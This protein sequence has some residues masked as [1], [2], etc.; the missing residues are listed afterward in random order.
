MHEFLLVFRRDYK[1]KSVQPSPEKLQE[2]LKHWTEWFGKLKTEDKL[3]VPPQRF[4]AAG[5]VLQHD[6]T[7]VDGPVVEHK[8]SIGGL[9]FIK[10]KDYMEA[11]KIAKGCPTLELGG[12]VEIRQVL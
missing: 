12:N 4:D 6:K 5:K 10:A 1:T 3:V 11:E 7:V 9:I 2:H 8:D